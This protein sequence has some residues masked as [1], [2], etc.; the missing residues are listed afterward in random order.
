MELQSCHGFSLWHLYVSS[1][2]IWTIIFHIFNSKNAK[3][4]FNQQHEMSDFILFWIVVNFLSILWKKKTQFY[5]FKHVL[6]QK[7]TT[8]Q[9]KKLKKE[10]NIAPNFFFGFFFFSFWKSC[11]NFLENLI[12]AKTSFFPLFFGKLVKISHQY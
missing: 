8:C 6:Q 12:L 4:S 10:K 2:T 3:K 5:F 9:I 11:E 1:W 7:F